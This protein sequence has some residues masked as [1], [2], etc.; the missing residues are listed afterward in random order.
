LMRY[1]ITVFSHKISGA[2]TGKTV[3]EASRQNALSTKTASSSVTAKPHSAPPSPVASAAVSRSIPALI[4]AAGLPADKLSASIVSFA[5]FFSLPLK[6]E[7][8]VAIRRQALSSSS[9]LTQAEEAKPRAKPQAKPQAAE[10]TPGLKTAAQDRE[11]LSLAAAAA[12]SK[13]LEL[14]PQGLENFAEAIDPDWQKRQEEGGQRRRRNKNHDEKENFPKADEIAA[15]GVKEMALKY[16]E[17]DPL[18]DILNRLPGKNGQ[19]WMVFPFSFSEGGRIFNVSL[20][21]LLEMDNQALSQASCS[22]GLI[23][24]DIVENERSWLFVMDNWNVAAKLAVYLQPEL[25]PKALASLS[26]ELARLMEIP[27]ERISVRNRAETFPCEADFATVGG[28]ATADGGIADNDN[29]LR[30]IDEA[31]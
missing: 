26:G 10:T 21:I 19:R 23:A 22:A 12:E 31:V 16:V 5:R 3:L 27:S 24:L 18:L 29:L 28:G 30:S 7:L 14:H 20:R 9:A 11:A 8:M 13:G 2:M 6:P 25:P 17:K 15:S 4:A 1:N